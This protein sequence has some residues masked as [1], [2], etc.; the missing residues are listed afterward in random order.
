[1]NNENF[2]MEVNL[3]N[4]V[5]GRDSSGKAFVDQSFSNPAAHKKSQISVAGSASCLRLFNKKPFISTALING[6]KI[7]A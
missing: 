2:T 4:F 6:K 3:S 5:G 7:T 1:M